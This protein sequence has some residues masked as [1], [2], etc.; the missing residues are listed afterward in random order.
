[1]AKRQ[2]K[3][4]KF[5]SKSKCSPQHSLHVHSACVGLLNNLCRISTSYN[6]RQLFNFF[7]SKVCC[8]VNHP[9]NLYS[10]NYLQRH[11]TALSFSHDRNKVLHRCDVGG[12]SQKCCIN[13]RVFENS[14]W[15]QSFC[16][17]S[18]IRVKKKN[19]KAL[20]HIH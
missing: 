17:S 8:L 14:F 6:G 9:L 10:N 5:S 15:C 20:F 2:D 4:L 12:V 18:W 3:N 16:L 11:I 19:I 1:M 13:R 7:N